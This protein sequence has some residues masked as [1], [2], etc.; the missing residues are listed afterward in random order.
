NTIWLQ[1]SFIK[2]LLEDSTSACRERIAAATG[3]SPFKV[4]DNQRPERTMS[5]VENLRLSVPSPAIT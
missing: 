4:G 1:Y 5:G 3:P 2:E